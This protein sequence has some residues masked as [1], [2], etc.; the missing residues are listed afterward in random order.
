MVE[1]KLVNMKVEKNNNNSNDNQNQNSN[2]IEFR[3]IKKDAKEY[4]IIFKSTQNIFIQ[5]NL[6]VRFAN[7]IEIISANSS[8][9][10]EIFPYNGI[11][12]S[13][14]IDKQNDLII[15]IKPI[16]ICTKVIIRKKLENICNDTEFI[17]V[18]WDNIFIINLTRRPDRK[19]EMIKKLKDANIT[20]YYFLE[21]YDGQTQE[22]TDNFNLVKQK[23]N[24]PIVTSGHF[25]CLLS[26]IK[27]IKLAIK[28]NYDYV[29]I[30]ED[31]VFFLDDFVN[32][33]SNLHVPKFDIMYLGG[34]TSKKKI[35]STDWAFSNGNKIMGAYGYVMGKNIYAEIL[36]GLEKLEEYVDMYYIKSVQPNYITLVLNDYIKTDLATSDTSH[37]SKKMIKRLGYIK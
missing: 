11:I 30:L 6:Y 22:V 16:D 21:A 17:K 13:C 15:N 10:L 33:L 31:D 19:E 23:K 18:H 34:I 35:F 20:K 2:Q 24:I 8:D 14:Y 26:H 3:P 32:K 29:M 5:F 27:A 37:K 4:K 9:N 36:D 7:S 25:A 28:N 12:Y 1:I